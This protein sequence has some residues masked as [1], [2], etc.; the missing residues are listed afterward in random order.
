MLHQRKGTRGTLEAVG[1]NPRNLGKDGGF[2][3][4]A[5]RLFLSLERKNHL[6][7]TGAHPPGQHVPLGTI[8][9]R[10]KQAGANAE[11]I[12]KLARKMRYLF[13]SLFVGHFFD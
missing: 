4:N 9:I 6:R 13:I 10:E 12:L 11:V 1:R 8:M 5:S 7:R 3:L 2:S